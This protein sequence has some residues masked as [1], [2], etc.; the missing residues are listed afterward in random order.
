MVK[1]KDKITDK[2]DY[3]DVLSEFPKSANELD[4]YYGS[5]QEVGCKLGPL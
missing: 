4:A 3:Y 5:K 2:Y 1:T